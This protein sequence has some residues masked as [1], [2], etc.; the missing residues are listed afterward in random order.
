VNRT[1]PVTALA[2][3]NSPLQPLRL[4]STPELIADRIRAGI[5]D[6]TFPP[7]TQLAEVQLS[8][9]L[10]VSRGPVREAMQRLIQEGLL[11]SERNRGVFVVELDDD[12]ARDVYV[13]R[14]AVEKAAALRVARTGDAD[15]LAALEEVLRRLQEAVDNSWAEV[16]EID[17]EFHSTVVD[18][19]NSE[20]LQRM[21]RTLVAE[22]RL[23]LVRLEPF[24]PHKENVV[25]EHRDIL[26]AIRDRDEVLVRQ[27]ID[28]HMEEAAA[29]LSLRPSQGSSQS[30]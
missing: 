15:D 28:R 16:V 10:Q 4:R 17:L 26:E 25:T 22:T 2:A 19:C 11:R 9:Q 7:Q 13:A 18:R 27:L 8:R 30:V 29:R 24:Y 14:A 1:S 12:D 21:F 5:L 20:R 3:V 23:C 6:G